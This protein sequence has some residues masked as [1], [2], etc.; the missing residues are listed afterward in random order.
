MWS[1]SS[2]RQHWNLDEH[3]A[4]N[5]FTGLAVLA[6]LGTQE[7]CFNYHW[8]QLSERDFA[9]C[10]ISWSVNCLCLE[11]KAVFL[12]AACQ[13][14]FPN[15][16]QFFSFLKLCFS[17]SIKHFLFPSSL[18]LFHFS[19]ALQ[20]LSGTQLSPSVHV[21][22][23]AEWHYCVPWLHSKTVGGHRSP[24]RMEDRR[25]KEVRTKFMDVN[26]QSISKVWL[27]QVI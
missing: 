4:K 15:C 18:W 9:V 12:I 5:I 25:M 21:S 3:L 2:E 27:Q 16:L 23:P 19:I 22:S 13:P 24:W 20:Q 6:K 14:D 11:R 10:D 26:T 17:E 7:M 1:S 8:S